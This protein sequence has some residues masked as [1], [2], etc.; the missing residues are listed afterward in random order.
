MELFLLALTLV[1]LILFLSRP[2]DEEVPAPK[3]CTLRAHHDGE[4]WELG[5][6]DSKDELVCLLAWPLGWPKSVDEDFLFKAGFEV[7]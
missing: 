4:G 7:V 6:Y 5:V 3:G 2:K 1:S